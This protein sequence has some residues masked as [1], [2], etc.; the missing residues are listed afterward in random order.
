[1]IKRAF[2]VVSSGLALLLLWPLMGTI[3][4][5]LRAKHGAPVI[6]RQ[7]R[8]GLKGESFQL[9]KFR[10]MEQEAGM[11][12]TTGEDPRIHRLGR[13][14]RASKLDE[15]PQF[16]D[17]FRGRMSIVGPRPEVPEFVEYWPSGQRS[18]ILSVRP[19]ITDPA[20]VQF[21]H[22]AEF[23]AT[24]HDPGKAYIEVVLPQKCGLYVNY[25]EDQSF[26]K[27]IR[28]V[29]ATLVA[30]TRRVGSAID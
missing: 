26:G 7:T 30:L 2:D 21:R 5:L 12:V 1:M 6:F 23:L 17:V 16:W 22:E 11:L 13:V 25:V 10:T 28:V 9:H 20:S 4:L 18:I 15:L 3:G 27:D 19:G 24:F 29:F 8:V 14:L